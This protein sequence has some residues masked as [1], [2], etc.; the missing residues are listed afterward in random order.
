MVILALF[1]PLLASYHRR[2]ETS[3]QAMCH[4]HR[5]GE[6][7]FAPHQKKKALELFNKNSHL[8]VERSRPPNHHLLGARE[9]A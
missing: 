5:R 6:D 4:I 8:R 9:D 3:I 7:P 2:T 1:Q